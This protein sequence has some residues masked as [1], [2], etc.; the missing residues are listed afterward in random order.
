MNKLE[1]LLGYS[2]RDNN[3]SKISTPFIPC[4]SSSFNVYQW[5][6]MYR[7]GHK[8]G[9]ARLKTSVYLRLQMKMESPLVCNMANW[10][11]VP[12]CLSKALST[13]KL[14]LRNYRGH[15]VRVGN[16][17]TLFTESV[18]KSVTPIFE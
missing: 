8:F 4:L 1:A 18:T 15:T 5:S 16:K 12:T 11:A 13:R 14:C 17:G 7:L 9:N 6:I 2:I 3:R 10:S